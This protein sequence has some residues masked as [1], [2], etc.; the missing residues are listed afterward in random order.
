MCQSRV[1]A[2][3]CSRSWVKLLS[4]L[5]RSCKTASA[6]R[7]LIP[8]ILGQLS[9]WLQNENI[10]QAGFSAV[11][12]DDLQYRDGLGFITRLILTRLPAFNLSSC[13]LFHEAKKSHL[14]SL[15]ACASTAAVAITASI[16]RTSDTATGRNQ[17]TCGTQTVCVVADSSVNTTVFKEDFPPSDCRFSAQGQLLAQTGRRVAFHFAD[18][19][20]DR[21]HSRHL[22]DFP[23]HPG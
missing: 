4:S 2:L 18:S 9:A 3:G 6:F 1:P 23:D 7:R 12:K 17:D 19:S 21:S 20:F 10:S 15:L 22:L 14:F 11:T 5:V 8:T 13:C 16:N